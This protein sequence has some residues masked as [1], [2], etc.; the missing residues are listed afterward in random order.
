MQRST[1]DLPDSNSGRG[2][3]GER[4]GDGGRRWL[5]SGESSRERRARGREGEVARGG[6]LKQVRPPYPLADREEARVD[7][8]D[9]RELLATAMV[10]ARGSR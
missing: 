9:D 6:A 3:A 2:V 5:R 10:T 7:E 4:D 1:A 8:N